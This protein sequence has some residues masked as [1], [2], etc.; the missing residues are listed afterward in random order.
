MRFS[1]EKQPSIKKAHSDWKLGEVG[2]ELGRQW[3]AMTEAQKAKYVTAADKDKATWL[4]THPKKERPV[5][6]LKAE[7]KGK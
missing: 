3:K 7:K 5:R 6:K 2:R 4:V 1:S